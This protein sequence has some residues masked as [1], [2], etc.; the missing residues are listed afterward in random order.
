MSNPFAK[1]MALLPKQEKSVGKIIRIETDGTVEVVNVAETSS[2]IV[3][4]GTDSYLVG[5]YV[6]IVDG[7][8]TSKL[9]A[10]QTILQEQMDI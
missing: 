5:D 3:K 10:A 9:P 4:G 7:I 2:T 1:F 8:I 6:F